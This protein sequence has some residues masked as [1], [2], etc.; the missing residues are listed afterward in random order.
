MPKIMKNIG[1]L[2]VCEKLHLNLGALPGNFPHKSKPCPPSNE[3]K[4]NLDP[5][6]IGS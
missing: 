2:A 1:D 5:K 6:D 4:I 3:F